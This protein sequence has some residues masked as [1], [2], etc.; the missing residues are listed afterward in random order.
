MRPLV[1]PADAVS[2]A[3]LNTQ[4]TEQAGRKLVVGGGFPS[5]SEDFY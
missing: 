3:K 5:R 4:H 1:R 2:T